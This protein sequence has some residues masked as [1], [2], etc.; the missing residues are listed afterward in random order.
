VPAAANT[1]VEHD[2]LQMQ[3]GDSLLWL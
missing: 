3:A 2:M 1:K